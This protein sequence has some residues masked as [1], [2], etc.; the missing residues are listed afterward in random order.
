MKGN[1]RHILLFYYRKSEEC[2]SDKKKVVKSLVRRYIK[3]TPVS[4]WFSKF[5]SDNFDVNDHV[6]EDQSKTK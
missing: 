4:N 1:F 3:D 2:C 6:L 5:R